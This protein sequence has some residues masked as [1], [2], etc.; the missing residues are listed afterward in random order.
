MPRPLFGEVVRA[1]VAG[2]FLIGATIALGL[3]VSFVLAGALAGIVTAV[4]GR[5]Y[6]R[7]FRARADGLSMAG[8]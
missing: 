4:G 5:R 6:D 3:L 1:W 7:R 2:M 8:S